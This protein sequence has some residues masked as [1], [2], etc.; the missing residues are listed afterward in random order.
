MRKIKLLQK[1]KL[2]TGGIQNVEK[3]LIETGECV[4]MCLWIYF[5]QELLCQQAFSC[6][7]SKHNAHLSIPL[8]W[9][10]ES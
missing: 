9:I 5:L 10:I 3:K 6:S 1:G 4:I 8:P 2:F 7:V